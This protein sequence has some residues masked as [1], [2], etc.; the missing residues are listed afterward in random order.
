MLRALEGSVRPAKKMEVVE[1]GCG[2][3]GGSFELSKTLGESGKRVVG[4]GGF[5]SL[6]GRENSTTFRL[7]M[8]SF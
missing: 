4:T 6:R 5:S 8:V 7:D 1:V 2:A 3:G